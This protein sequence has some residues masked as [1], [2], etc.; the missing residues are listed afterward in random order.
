MQTYTITQVSNILGIKPH[1]I[2]YW[3]KHL[4]YLLVKKD[5]HGKRVYSNQE[6]Y[7]LYRLQF[8]IYKKRYT[9]QG[10]SKALMQEFSSKQGSSMRVSFLS[11]LD[12]LEK[13]RGTLEAA[14]SIISSIKKQDEGS[15]YEE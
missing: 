2:R 14:K 10:A 4:S 6:L 5:V 15:L 13:Q 9:L 3:E 8:L 1:I 11:L 12:R 7:V